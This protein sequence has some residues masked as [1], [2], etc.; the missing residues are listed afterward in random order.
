MKTKEDVQRLSALLL[1]I[2]GAL[3]AL[4]LLLA[5]L[6]GR[7]GPVTLFG[8]GASLFGLVIVVAVLVRERR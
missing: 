7:R 3:L 2:N 8:I 5:V 6:S 4:G 1:R